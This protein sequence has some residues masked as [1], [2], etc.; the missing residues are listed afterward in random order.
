MRCAFV[1]LKPAHHAVVL[2]IFRRFGLGYAEVLG[3]TISNWF[4]LNHWA[5]AA[6]GGAQQIRDPDTQ[7]LAGLDVVVSRLVGIGEQENAG[8]RRR[9]GRFFNRAGRGR[10]QAAQLR[11]ERRETRRKRWVAGAAARKKRR[12]RRRCVGIAQERYGRFSPLWRNREG[13]YPR[14]RFR[15]GG[16]VRVNRSGRNR[17]SC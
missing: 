17:G 9:A 5:A 8:S 4:A 2:Q 15:V 6:T 16:L 3:Q 11:F 10:E 12:R 1:Q 14:R 7:G 13:R